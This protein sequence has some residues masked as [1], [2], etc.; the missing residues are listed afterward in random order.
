MINEGGNSMRKTILLTLCLVAVAG[1]W[2][3]TASA[4]AA[5]GIDAWDGSIRTSNPGV[6]QAGSHPDEIVTT[7]RFN[8]HIDEFGDLRPDAPPRNVIVD[9]P[10]GFIGSATAMPTCNANDLPAFP[11]DSFFNPS[12]CSPNTVV[13]TITVRFAQEGPEAWSWTSPI[14]NMTPPPGQPARFGFLVAGV[15]N[16][17]TASARTDGD[18]GITL[19]LGDISQ[20]LT[21]MSATTTFWGVPADPSHDEKRC[22]DYFLGNFDFCPLPGDP[23][24]G[25]SSASVGTVKPLLTLPTSCSPPGDGL[26]FDVFARSWE[27]PANTDAASFTTHLEPPNET[28]A[29]GVTGCDRVP[30]TPRIDVQP[31]TDNAE[32]PS[33]L[34]VDLTVPPDGLNN[35][36]GISQS[37]LKDAKVS[38]PEGMTLNPGYADGVGY[39]AASQVGLTSGNG[40]P[41]RFSKDPARCPDAAQLGEVVIDT[42]LLAEPL[43]GSV[44]VAQQN[45]PEAPG[46]ENPFDSLLA[47]YI[48]AE[49]SGVRAKLAGEVSPDPK[50]GQVITT[51]LNNPEVPFERFSLKFKGGQRAPLAM[52]SACGTYTSTAELTPWAR[53][54]APVTVTDSFQVS[55]GPDGGPCLANSPGARAFAPT[56]NAGTA[57]NNAGS[58]SD[59][60]LRM[61]RKD[62]EQEITSFSMDMPPG[63]TG[64]LAGV[65]K[66]SD[67]AIEASKSKSGARELASPSCPL[68]SQIGS[69]LVGS[70]VGSLLTYVPGKVYLAGPYKGSPLSVATITPAK[71]GPFDVGTVV[72]RSALRIDPETA[73]VSVDSQGSDPIPTI[74]DGITLHVRD[75]RVQL[76]RPEFT[77]NPT[78][79]DRMAIIAK[80]TGTGA[81]FVSPLDDAIASPS[82]PFQAAN[83]AALPFKPKL[84]FKLKGGTKRGQFPA[85]QATLRAR[86][87][88]ANLAKTTV[89]L[90]RSEFIEQGHI[91]TVCTRVQFAAKQCPPGSI[92]GHARATTPLFDTPVEGPVYLR[93]NGGE[94]LLPDLVVSLKNGEIEVA[95]AG[96]IDSVKGR[97]RNAFNVIPDAPVTKFT[98]NMLG[99]KKGLLVNHLDL[100]EVTSRADV[101][102]VGQNGKVVE[103]R[104]KMGTSCGKVR[105]RNR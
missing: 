19:D 25:P 26:R 64:K 22:Q 18:L 72:V 91:R 6:L 73:Q 98:L 103:T 76:D 97:V 52:P 77:L 2:V 37:N 3:V 54:L 70:G 104:P 28:T 88:D 35:P 12:N 51:F 42:P 65:A 82:N 84:S 93:S 24:R 48:V 7:L 58:Y 13:G 32:A 21:P 71:T 55:H 95:L 11:R 96:F 17:I 61:T 66:C 68:S 59:F 99:G 45:D 33:G 101:K 43:T 60:L 36:K 100:C 105:K 40:F 56:L 85:F 29:L 75:I 39:C 89:V 62:G 69:V 38:L 63:L 23:R 49:G 10:A 50:T 46:S 31:T 9:L 87:G 5:F 57:N 67:A 16:F 81:D 79:C 30:F 74:R 80:L 78:N 94:R 92:Y 41:V 90:P 8:E 44:Y 34:E 20:G 83:C 15:T 47:L 4:K 86:P 14:F 102:M 1:L 53:P 27:K